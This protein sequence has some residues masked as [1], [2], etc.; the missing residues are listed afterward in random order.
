[1]KAQKAIAG[2]LASTLAAV[3]LRSLTQLQANADTT[4]TAA[5][6]ISTVIAEID[7]SFSTT[8]NLDKLPKK[9]LCALELAVA[10]DAAALDITEVELLYDTGAEAAEVVVTPELEGTV[11]TYEDFGGELRIRWAT[12]LKN[13]DYWLHDEVPLLRISGKVDS[14]LR[15]YR[16]MLRLVPAS[17]ETYEGSGVR[18]TEI[19]AGYVDENGKVFQCKTE[20]TDGAVWTTIDDTGATIYW[21]INMD[22]QINMADAVLLC[23]MISEEKLTLGAAAYANADWEHDGMLTLSDVTLMLQNVL[24]KDEAAESTAN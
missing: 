11:F 1:M 14:S 17:R 2:I 20:C 4:D 8:L 21:D 18:N 9:G 13:A 6:S 15:G 5:I 3:A 7:G 22:A 24:K 23:R 19:F 10:Y 12:A 16:K